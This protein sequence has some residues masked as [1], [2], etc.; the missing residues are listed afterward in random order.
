MT[1][2]DRNYL[3]KLLY[4]A[5]QVQ[6]GRAKLPADKSTAARRLQAKTRSYTLSLAIDAINDGLLEQQHDDGQ[7]DLFTAAAAPADDAAP[8]GASAYIEPVDADTFVVYSTDA[9]GN[10]AAVLQRYDGADIPVDDNSADALPA[11]YVDYAEAEDVRQIREEM[12]LEAAGV[13]R[14]EDL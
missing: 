6:N 7:Q 1:A 8:S 12:A 4:D 5:R 3:L 14:W 11:E 10:H 9:A 13:E 2:V